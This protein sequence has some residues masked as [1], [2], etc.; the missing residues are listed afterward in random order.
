MAKHGVHR[1][2]GC[3]SLD[4]PPLYT[5]YVG[6][7]FCCCGDFAQYVSGSREVVAAA[8][9]RFVESHEARGHRVFKSEAEAKAYEKRIRRL[10]R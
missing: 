7:R 1:F 3:I 6:R 8:L 9:R 4:P 2:G 5:A 10:W